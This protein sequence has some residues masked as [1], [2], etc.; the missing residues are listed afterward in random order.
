MSHHQNIDPEECLPLSS[1]Q[2]RILFA[3]LLE[4]FN[5]QFNAAFCISIEG[6]VDQN[7]FHR[8]LGIAVEEVDALRARIVRQDNGY[9]QVIQRVYEIPNCVVDLMS[10]AEPES[11]AFKYMRTDLKQVPDF[12][13]DPLWASVL[14][15][16][17]IA[18]TLWYLR[19]HHII[20]DGYSLHLFSER[21]AQIYTDL[22]AG[23]CIRAGHGNSLRELLDE[24]SRYRQSNEFLQDEQYWRE[25]V[26]EAPVPVSLSDGGIKTIVGSEGF[27]RQTCHLPCVIT[28]DLRSLKR[29]QGVDLPEIITAA[30]AAYIYRIKNVEDLI[31][32]F[33]VTGRIGQL[34]RKTP[35]MM[36]NILPLRL[37]LHGAMRVADLVRQVAVEIR[38][39]LQ[40]QRYRFE[41]LHQN[42]LGSQGKF[43]CSIVNVMRFWGDLVFA[44]CR[45]TIYIL[46]TGPVEDLSIIVYDRPRATELQIDFDANVAIY[47]VDDIAAH[48]KRYLTLLKAVIAGQTQRI[49]EIDLLDSNERDQVLYEWN[50]SKA[51]YP[52]E[53]CV[54]ELFEEQV[55]R[56]PEAVAVE[57]GEGKLSYVE[58][59]RRANRLAHYLRSVGVKP[60]TRV[61]TV[62]KRSVDLVIA[63]LAILKC[64]AAYVPIDPSF[65]PERKAFL[66]TDSQAE[67]VLLLAGVEAT[68]IAAARWINLD[69]TKLPEDKAENLC[70]PL[71]S[72]AMAY[73]M[74]TS[75]ST[76]YPK[77]VIVPHR[78]IARLVLNN[79]YAKFEATDRVAFASNP[80]F[81][82]VTMEVWAPLLNGGCIVIVDHDT[83]LEPA[84]FQQTLEQHGVTVLWL[85]VGLFNQY[86]DLLGESFARL[87]YLMVGGD[88]LDPK[89]IAQ[90]LANHPPQHLLNGYGP[91]ETT[92][93]AATYEISSVEEHSRS[94]PI[95]KPISNTQI[96]ILDERGE[97]VPIGVRGNI[98][99]GGDGLAW[100]YVNRPESTAE[101]FV[102]NPYGRGEGARLYRTGDLGR[103][104]RDGN[105]EFLGR[106]DFQVKLRGFRIELEEIE[107]R[108]VEH[109][110]VKEA[111]VVAVEQE[112]GEKQL[113]A[114]YT[115][116]SSEGSGSGGGVEGEE[117]R[118][119]LRERVPEYMVPMGY[120]Q[121]EKLPLTENG[122]VDRKALPLFQADDYNMKEY[123]EPDGETERLLAAIWAEVLK[124]E[125]VGRHDSFFQLGG[126]S[127]LAMRVASRIQQLLGVKMTM[128]YIFA[129]PIF[130]QLA[131]QVITMQLE[132]FDIEELGRL[133]SSPRNVS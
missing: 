35:G 90:V 115:G 123:E 53:Q 59:N 44:E 77:G 125:R 118:K 131:E 107:A 126:H 20:I 17:E 15:K 110:G 103:W 95:G 29:S 111:V 5:P 127:L 76:G 116:G 55:E 58:L 39:G 108:L 68:P 22:A 114:Y 14:F 32:G 25:H 128:A 84:R 49:N 51:E 117:L 66:I 132:K 101:R 78:A 75:G 43:F 80:A 27:L 60:D 48:Q 89:V 70:V 67:V 7:L 112:S 82:A 1:A 10:V 11:E 38:H 42:L 130:S 106:N 62:L 56:T 8:A 133:L 64:G 46:S 92:T 124:V 121:L 50:K 99:I 72:E 81:D 97:P 19:A 96:Y 18:K 86:A 45:G 120:M 3:Q 74:Y 122:K 87:R 52:R 63:E 85:T 2:S 12:V 79:G 34:A 6:K 65:P 36:A 109:E 88:A 33:V 73:L 30:L 98:Y 9:A 129:H 23:V 24:D 41:D 37:S 31:L 47:T 28:E 119:Y 91:T 26:V 71:D 83:L 105:I 104:R 57:C 4:P 113:V 16:T 40:R 100:G 54:H 61:G 102:P 13:K 21:V 93:F 69:E 94:I